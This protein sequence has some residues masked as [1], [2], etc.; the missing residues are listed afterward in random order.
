M[1]DPTP[2][3]IALRGKP[4]KGLTQEWRPA[5]TVVALLLVAAVVVGA[6]LWTNMSFGGG[7][8]VP[9][10]TMMPDTQ[11]SQPAV[12]EPVVVGPAAIATVTAY[13]PGG[14][15]TEND[16]D[17]V[18]S[19]ADGDPATTWS[20]SCYSSRYM[21]GK[22]GVGLVVSF[23]GPA[24]AAV[25]VDVQTAPYQLV[26]FASDA[27]TL[28]ASFEEWGPPLGSTAFANEAETVVSPVPPAPARHVL[29]LLKELGPDSTCS[30]ANPYRG[31]LGEVAVVG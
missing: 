21:G 22:Q 14:D 18:L 4:A 10:S 7:D 1:H 17:A 11:S 6:L 15:G 8:P 31:R 30:D 9:P 16:S 23:D 29:I 2:P 26:F 25:T 24:Q 27:E 20:T 28:P 3:G 13:D 5:F 12:D 19:L